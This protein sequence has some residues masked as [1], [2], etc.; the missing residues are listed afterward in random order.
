[1]YG[2][3]KRRNM[4]MQVVLFIITCGI[5]GLYWFYETASEMKVVAQDTEA[6][7]GLW[8]FLLIVPVLNFYAH[9]KYCELFE[10]VSADHFSLWL[11]FVIGLVFPPAVWFIVQ[12]DL[13]E[14][15]DSVVLNPA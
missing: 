11:L 4:L 8:T 5:Y 14:K 1:M 2:V 13:N 15:A 9:Y 12:S 7:P 10:D 6:S 3:I